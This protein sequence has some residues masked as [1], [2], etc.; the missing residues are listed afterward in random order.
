MAKEQ[1]KGKEDTNWR[2]LKSGNS[3]QSA[4]KGRDPEAEIPQIYCEFE[5]PQSLMSQNAVRTAYVHC[6]YAT[7]NGQIAQLRGPEWQNGRLIESK[8][9]ARK[10]K[11][12]R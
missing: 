4:L 5:A 11:L 7:R 8:L 2:T 1:G 3:H 9:I 12:H 10:K 6:D